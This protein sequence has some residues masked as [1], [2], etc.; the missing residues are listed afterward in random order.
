MLEGVKH[1]SLTQNVLAQY[2]RQDENGFESGY[3]SFRLEQLIDVLL[4]AESIC[5]QSTLVSILYLCYGFSRYAYLLYA[6]SPYAFL[7]Y[8]YL[9]YGSSRYA[10]LRYAFS[11]YA[12]LHYALMFGLCLFALC[13]LPLSVPYCILTSCMIPETGFCPSAS[14]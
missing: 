5:P 14:I 10:H 11:R 13:L 6:F 2:L 12:Y 1:S 4:G 7:C 3:V 8:A 9:R